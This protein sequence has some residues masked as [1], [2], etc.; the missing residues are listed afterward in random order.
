MKR[1]V[2]SLLSNTIYYA[3]VN[4]KNNKMSATDRKDVTN[5]CISAVFEW[6]VNHIND[7]NLK[8]YSITYPSSEYELVMRKKKL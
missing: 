8:E 5:N 2:V 1:L 3:T 6:F 4:E 7:D